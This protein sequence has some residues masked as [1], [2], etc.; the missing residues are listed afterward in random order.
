MRLQA[1]EHAPA[2]RPRSIRSICHS[3]RSV[4]YLYAGTQAVLQRSSCSHCS[5]ARIV[6]YSIQPRCMLHDLSP[7]KPADK[8]SSA[9]RHLS[10][11]QPVEPEGSG[12]YV[13]V[14]AADAAVDLLVQRFA[15]PG[16]SGIQELVRMHAG[17]PS[18]RSEQSFNQPCSPEGALLSSNEV[19]ANHTHMGIL[20]TF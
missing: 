12:P 11:V 20:S 13:T 1:F 7:R 15:R 2:C 4:L 3:G 18:S 16:S 8:S 19:S 10:T 5:L 6:H 9:C 17:P 14:A